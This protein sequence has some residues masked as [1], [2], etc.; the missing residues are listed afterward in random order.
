MTTHP[1]GS[2]DL[3]VDHYRELVEQ[4]SDVVTV[5]DRDGTV[6]YQSPS[7]RTVKGW[8]PADLVGE[9]MLSYIHPDD[10]DRVVGLMRAVVGDPGNRTDRIEYRFETPDGEYIW[11]SSTGSN[12]GPDSPFDGYVVSSREVTDRKQ[13]EER[14]R[15]QRDRLDAFS[16]V[17]SHDLTAPLNVIEGSLDLAEETGESRHFERARRAVARIEGLTADLLALAREGDLVGDREAVPLAEAAADAW[18][19]VRTPE[20]TLDVTVTATVSAD[21][22]RLK[23]LLENLFRNAVDH[24]GP[25]VEVAIEG[26]PDGAGFAVADDGPGLPDDRERLFE[27]GVST[28]EDGTGLGLA[29]VREIVDGHGWSIDVTDAGRGGAR[30]EVR[31]VDLVADDA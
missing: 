21:P 25:G 19:N 23:Q 26:L 5:V 3:S 4:I 7:S 1:D 8:E 27:P 22:S 17:V 16:T 10:R 12:P 28:A 31:D 14:L 9:N 30:F 11:L 18:A 29:I 24:G 13:L 2:L 15:R 6:R 20:A